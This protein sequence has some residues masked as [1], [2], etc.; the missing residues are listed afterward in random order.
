VAEIAN[1][2]ADLGEH[3]QGFEIREMVKEVDLNKDGTVSLEEF[4]TVGY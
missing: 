1:V 3:V 2:M 4:E